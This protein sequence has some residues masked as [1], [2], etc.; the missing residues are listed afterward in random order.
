M[1]DEKPKIYS[2][3]PIEPEDEE[4]YYGKY[5]KMSRDERRWSRK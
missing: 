2:L 4:A 1:F 3:T 5:T